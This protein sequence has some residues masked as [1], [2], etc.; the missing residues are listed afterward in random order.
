MLADLARV[1]DRDAVAQVARE[2]QVVGD[3]E[4]RDAPLA[5]SSLSRFMICAWMLTSSALVGSSRMSSGGSWVS[6]VAIMTRCFMPP[7]SSCG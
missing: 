4:H 6:A 2:R 3:E 1:D 7:E 5:L